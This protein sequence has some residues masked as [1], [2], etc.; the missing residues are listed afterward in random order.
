[1]TALAADR[2]CPDQTF[3]PDDLGVRWLMRGG[4]AI[5]APDSVDCAVDRELDLHVTL[6]VNLSGDL[7]APFPALA[8]DAGLKLRKA[9]A[10]YDAATRVIGGLRGDVETGGRTLMSLYVAGASSL[11]SPWAEQ[12][13]SPDRVDRLFDVSSSGQALGLMRRLK[14]DTQAVRKNTAARDLAAELEAMLEARPDMGEGRR[15]S[16]AILAT[17]ALAAELLPEEAAARVGAQFAAKGVPIIAIETGPGAPSKALTPLAERSGGAAFSAGDAETLYR[18][19][20]EAL[21]QGR[22][23]CAVRVTAPDRFFR[24]GEL[25]LRLRRRMTDGCALEQIATISCDAL[26]F[27]ER[28]KP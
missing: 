11:Q 27:E 25:Q 23:F 7:A 12:S 21:D 18:R 10:V 2:L 14:S 19:M 22:R 3:G 4:E 15:R 24:E 16:L 5:D 13:F 17:D 20:S 28:I 6:F 26:R 1:M 8:Q 9:E